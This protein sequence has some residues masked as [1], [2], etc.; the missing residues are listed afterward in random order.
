MWE[1]AGRGEASATRS[2]AA[3][4]RSKF[5][6]VNRFFFL[7]MSFFSS[8]NQLR[9]YLCNPTTPVSGPPTSE[10][11]DQALANYRPLNW[12]H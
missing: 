12:A 4:L 7:F 8:T 9:G 5:S 10:L 1:G 3:P 11:L 2:A 6:Q